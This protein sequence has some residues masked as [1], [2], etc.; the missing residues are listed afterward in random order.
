MQVQ[1]SQVSHD[2]DI[3]AVTG[4]DAAQKL[5]DTTTAIPL[6]QLYNS[7]SLVTSIVKANIRRGIIKSL[8]NC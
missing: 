3:D 6:S 8:F 1:V 7:L 5:T 4:K 2:F